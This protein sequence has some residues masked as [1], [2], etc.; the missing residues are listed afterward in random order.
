MKARFARVPL[1]VL[2]LLSGCAYSFRPPQLL[3]RG[4]IGV[5]MSHGMTFVAQG[6]VLAHSP[7]FRELPRFVACVPAAHDHAVRARRAGR[8]ARA[9][10]ILGATLGM[11][12]MVGFGALADRDHAYAYL[13]AALGTGVV[14]L[15]FSAASFHGRRVAF[16]HG[17]DA[18]NEYNDAVGSLGATCLDLRFAVPSGPTAPLPYPTPSP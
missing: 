4:E 12:A 1:V 7:V 5:T 8:S 18:V 14:G 17:L 13:G 10:A 3:A 11:G 16:G 15:G 6:R 9:F 2:V